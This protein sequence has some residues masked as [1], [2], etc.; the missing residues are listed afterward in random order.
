[1]TTFPVTYRLDG[2]VLA[3]AR[4]IVETFVRVGVEAVVSAGTR[5][6]P[7]VGGDVPTTWTTA[8]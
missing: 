3:S 5:R 2:P 6:T 1:M 7:E 4:L 8:P